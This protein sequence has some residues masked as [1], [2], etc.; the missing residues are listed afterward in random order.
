V[1][2]FLLEF[3]AKVWPEYVSIAAVIDTDRRT[4]AKTDIPEYVALAATVERFFL[5]L[6][7]NAT[8][9]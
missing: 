9:V 7:A 3:V 4:L 8:G 1:V 2:K 6:V 5:R